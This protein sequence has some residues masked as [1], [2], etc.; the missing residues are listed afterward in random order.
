MSKWSR[1]VLLA[2]GVGGAKLAVGLGHVLPIGA[3]T[4]IVNTGDDFEHL[5]LYVTPDL[6]TVL[7]NL[8]GIA[9]PETGWGLAED[10]FNAIEMAGK[11]GGA[12]WFRLGDA[13]IGT[14]IVRTQMLRSGHRLSA[15]VTHFANSFGV[16]HRV[17]PM[18]D[19]PVHT[20]VHT[21]D[22]KLSF[23]EYFVRDR[24]QPVVTH[25]EFAGIQQ[26][27]SAPG[28][29]ETLAEADLILFGPSNPFLSLDPILG[30]AGIRDQ[31]AS[32]AA[33]V[34]AVS[35]IV[36]GKAVKGPAA[37]LMAE[38]GLDVSPRGIAQY[39][40]EL[41]DG[42]I[43]DTADQELVAAIK[44]GGVNAVSMNTIMH[45]TADKTTLASAILEWAEAF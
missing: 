45:T 40:E 18:T 33:P 12:S 22:G 32:S 8:A 43:L 23:Q 2:G 26:A 38:L 6:D 19:D 7:Y 9:N 27:Q 21:A 16:S 5:G 17:V 29:L 35:P 13:D 3:L 14:N 31:I 41:L 37:K 39:Y 11:L 24:W 36:G 20:L 4:V 42:I 28:V 1:V 15:V 34:I 10:T 30:L 25:L 44:S